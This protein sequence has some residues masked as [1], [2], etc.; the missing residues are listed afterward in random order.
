MSAEIL[1]PFTL[2]VNGSIAVTTDPDVQQAQHVS[3]LVTT[4][5][6]E[7]VMKP[8]YG[9]PVATY[10]FGNGAAAIAQKIGKDVMQAMAA[11]EPGITVNSVSPVWNAQGGIAEI[12][13]D[14]LAAPEDTGQVQTATVNVGGT[15]TVQ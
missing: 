14:Y 2:D 6:G 10:L 8:T 1:I 13:V 15:V 3:S 7:R 5:P 9:V 12:D 4:N 11:W